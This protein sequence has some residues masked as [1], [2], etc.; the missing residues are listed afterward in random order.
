MISEATSPAEQAIIT[1]IHCDFDGIKTAFDAFAVDCGRYPTTAEGFTVLLDC[2]TN[3][4]RGWH[5]PYLV[6]IPQDLWQRDYVYRFPGIHNTN[7]FDLYSRGYDGISKSG[8][9]DL[10]DIN[11]W[12]R[13]SPHGGNDFAPYHRQFYR[14]LLLQK[15]EKSPLFPLFILTLILFPF[16]GVVR[17]IASLFSPRVRALIDRHPTVH[18][19]WFVVSAAIILLF[20]K[21][22]LHPLVGR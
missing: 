5:G 9:E 10:D 17:L 7:G 19:I 12:D 14:Q 21:L 13:S 16:F 18:I 6:K 15:F 2:P 11:N 4:S 20:L 3:I 1:A 22:W 8:G